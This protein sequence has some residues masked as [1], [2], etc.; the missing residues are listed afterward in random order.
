[1]DSQMAAKSAEA[2]YSNKAQQN[3][4]IEKAIAQKQALDLQQQALTQSYE[5]KTALTKMQYQTKIKDTADSL[6]KA[7]AGILE[8]V[9]NDIVNLTALSDAK[10]HIMTGQMI[11]DNLSQSR[12]IDLDQIANEYT[13]NIQSSVN[14]FLANNSRIGIAAAGMLKELEANGALDTAKGQMEA[15]NILQTSY[16][17]IGQS[18]QNLTQSLQYYNQV[19][20]QLSQIAYQ[21]ASLEQNQRQFEITNDR[22]TAEANKPVVNPDYSVTYTD[23]LTKQ[24]VV[25]SMEDYQSAMANQDLESKLSDYSKVKDGQWI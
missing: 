13:N 15:S 4:Q 10:G 2:F 24:R 22:L 17:A 5:A 8:A 21:K 20:Q 18:S 11:L 6:N 3:Q 12:N 9:G 23:P 1:M 7:Q 16:A 19:A 14:T 25:G